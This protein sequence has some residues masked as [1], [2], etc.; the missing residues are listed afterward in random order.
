MPCP[1]LQL[2][3][4]IWLSGLIAFEPPF[5]IPVDRGNPIESTLFHCRG[6]ESWEHHQESGSNQCCRKSDTWGITPSWL[7]YPN[8]TIQTQR[9]GLKAASWPSPLLMHQVE[10]LMMAIAPLVSHYLMGIAAGGGVMGLYMLVCGF[11]QPLNLLPK[12][13]LTYPLY[14]LAYHSYAF[15]GE[16]LGRM[17]EGRDPELKDLNVRRDAMFTFGTCVLPS[18]IFTSQILQS[19]QEFLCL[20]LLVYLRRANTIWARRSWNFTQISTE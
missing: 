20:T 9:L 4:G 13:V 11:F 15:N 6:R 17:K 2:E 10:S 16:S 19:L 3:W 5:I 1:G 12:P 14:Y 8:N 18:N 7:F